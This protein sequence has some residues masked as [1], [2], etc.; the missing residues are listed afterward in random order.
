M[1]ALAKHIAQYHKHPQ[2]LATRW[3]HV[4]GIA[5]M[6]FAIMIPLSWLQVGLRAVF[7]TDLAWLGILVLL[8][9]YLFLDIPLAIIATIVLCFIESIASAVAQAGPT[10]HSFWLCVICAVIAWFLQSMGRLFDGKKL[11][12]FNLLRYVVIAPILMVTEVGF[13]LGQCKKLHQQVMDI[14][15][16]AKPAKIPTIKKVSAI[17]SKTTSQTKTTTSKS[18]G[19]AAVTTKKSTAA[20][21]KPATRKTT[22]TTAKKATSSAKTKTTT[23]KS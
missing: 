7:M 6:L 19:K 10:W 5:L 2:S 8:V 14:N 1:Q 23:R 21:K 15:T 3:L 13:W 16:P 22:K 20:A 12:S 17:V 11:T 18:P 4:I 9:Y